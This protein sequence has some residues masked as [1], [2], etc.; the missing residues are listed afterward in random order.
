M[1][2]GG[3]LASALALLIMTA[4][5]VGVSAQRGGGGGGGFVLPTR[6]VVLTT[7]VKLDPAQVKAAKVILDAAHKDAAVASAQLQ[8][9]HAAIG[10]AVQAKKSQADIDAAVSVYAKE[11]GDMAEREL[12]SL[13]QV[14]Q[15]LPEAQRTAAAGAI[16][17][18]VYAMRG[19]FIDKKWDVVPGSKSY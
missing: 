2:I 19:A 15:A 10:E 6:L 3:A 5:S 4:G 8:A 12:R 18:V 11:S 9:A 17:G 16:D 1:V 7:A 14:L 13:A